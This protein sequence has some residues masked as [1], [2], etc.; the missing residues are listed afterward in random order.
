[1]FE[2]NMESLSQQRCENNHL[3]AS[4]RCMSRSHDCRSRLISSHR[5][6]MTLNFLCY[7]I[8]IRRHGPVCAALLII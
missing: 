6:G 1:M 4:W 3:Q 2:I 8:G 5:C 7:S